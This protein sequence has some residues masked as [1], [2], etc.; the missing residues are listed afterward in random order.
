MPIQ[1]TRQLGY[2][3]IAP[4]KTI[5]AGDPLGNPTDEVQM[6][7]QNA[8]FNDRNIKPGTI[9]T[10]TIADLGGPYP[11][12]RATGLTGHFYR[13]WLLRV[14]RTPSATGQ[15]KLQ[16]QA[17]NAAAPGSV[18]LVI[19]QTD[20]ATVTS[21]HSL[22][23]PVAPKAIRSVLL[24]QSVSPDTWFIAELYIEAANVDWIRFYGYED[25]GTP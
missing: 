2:A 13:R 23:I 22:A 10:G 25:T 14:P 8:E 19:L 17:I 9:R 6:M 15:W 11:A 1:G 21:S 16:A 5:G 24:P 3:V 12:V 20:L 4:G 7:V 18:H